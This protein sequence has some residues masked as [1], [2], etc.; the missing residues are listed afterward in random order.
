MKSSDFDDEIFLEEE[1]EDLPLPDMTPN[2]GKWSLVPF[3]GTP[4]KL[5]IHENVSW[6]HRKMI[7]LFFGCEWEK[8]NG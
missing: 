2:I 5:L 8:I 4:L 7:S 1:E 6:F 3:P